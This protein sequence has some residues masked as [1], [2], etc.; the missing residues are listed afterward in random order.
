MS[1]QNAMKCMELMK[2]DVELQK[3]VKA[4][5]DAYTGEKT[6]AKTVFDEVLAPIAKEIGYECSYEDVEA[7][8]RPSGDEELS[9]DEVA[10]VAGGGKGA[11]GGNVGFC[12]VLGFGE[13]DTSGN[14]AKCDYVGIG[15]GE[16]C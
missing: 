1:Q 11:G 7:L 8:A 4:A 2:T 15:L 6:D 9:E 10:M 13:G 14:Y 16:W 3:K 5:M 12:I